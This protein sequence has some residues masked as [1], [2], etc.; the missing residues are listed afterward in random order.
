MKMTVER[1]GK[2]LVLELPEEWL[3]E[4]RIREG[5][6]I[7]GTAVRAALKARLEQ[8]E[9]RRQQGI[10][11]MRA[12]ARPLPPDWKFDREEANAR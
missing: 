10:A 9:E 2:H 11:E 3:E 8:L 1:Y 5:D 7:D 6:Q 12:L 4:F